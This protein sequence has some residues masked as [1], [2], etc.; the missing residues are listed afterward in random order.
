[1]ELGLDYFVLSSGIW[2]QS[3]HR[4]NQKGEEETRLQKQSKD[5]GVKN[6]SQLIFIVFICCFTCAVA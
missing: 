6:K 2:N 4:R 3:L 5:R 1:M